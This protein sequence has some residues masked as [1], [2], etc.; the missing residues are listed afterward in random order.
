MGID[1]GLITHLARWLLAEVGI[2][3]KALVVAT[4]EQLEG[5]G[6]TS[7]IPVPALKDTCEFLEEELQENFDVDVKFP[8]D[9]E[10]ASTSSSRRCRTT[11]SRRTR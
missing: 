11:C 4:R 9:V 10:G 2:V 1:H 7:A 5:V 3:P 8:F 6:N